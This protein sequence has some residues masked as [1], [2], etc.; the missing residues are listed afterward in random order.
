MTPELVPGE[1][2]VIARGVRR[3]VAPNPGMMTGPGTNTYLVGEKAVAVIDPGPRI[4][5]HID[6]IQS[7]SPGPIRWVLCT[8]T[9]PDHSPGAT[10][11]AEATGAEMIGIPAPEGKVQDTTFRPHRVP[12]DGDVLDTDEFSIRMVHTPGH[13]SN[14]LCFRHES[15]RMLFTGD[16][17]MSGSTVVIDPP[18]GDMKAYIESLER[19]KDLNLASLAPGHGPII[20]EPLEIVDWLIAHRLKREASV[21]AA[22]AA[23]PDQTLWDLTPHVYEDVDAKLH[24]LA[25]RSLLAHLLKLEVEGRVICVNDRWRVTTPA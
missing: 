3:L 1:A 8:H 21:I 22:T 24:R 25:S 2:L 20:D 6:A 23:H 11:L 19:L 4:D 9:H 15:H 7:Q 13:A 16:H 10:P 14:H 17:I 12:I 5:R 18:D